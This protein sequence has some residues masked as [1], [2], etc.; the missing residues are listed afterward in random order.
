MVSRASSS[1]KDLMNRGVALRS[2]RVVVAF[3]AAGPEGAAIVGVN[4][5]RFT[6][7]S[8]ELDAGPRRMLAIEMCLGHFKSTNSHIYNVLKSRTIR[9]SS[10]AV[11]FYQN[12]QLELY[13]SKTT[14]RLTLRQLVWHSS[15]CFASMTDGIIGFFR[16][17][18][19]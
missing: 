19:E 9:L 6:L 8:Y 17:L 4:V 16:T 10:T 12:K 14:N 18:D 1:G 5:N 13:A 2:A 11:Q 15:I 3:G 7:S